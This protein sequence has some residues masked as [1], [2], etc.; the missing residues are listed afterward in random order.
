MKKIFTLFLTLFAVSGFAQTEVSLYNILRGQFRQ[1]GV[2][3]IVS[4]MSG[5]SYTVLGLIPSSN[6][7]TKQEKLRIL[8]QIFPLRDLPRITSF[9]ATRKKFF[10]T[11]IPKKFTAAGCKKN[12]FGQR[13]QYLYQ[14]F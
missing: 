6:T 1:R 12:R 4:M 14:K 11:L 2:Y 8:L 7:A 3:G 9:Q 10:S 13:Q 5:E